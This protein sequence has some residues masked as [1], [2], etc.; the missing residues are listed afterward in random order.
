MQVLS[1]QKRPFLEKWLERTLATYPSQTHRFLHDEKDRFRNPVGHTLRE[2]LATIL[3]ELTGEMDP[4]RIG[5]ALESIVRLRAVQDFTPSQAVGFVY[6]LRE[7]LD[8]ELGGE[9][10]GGFTPP[11]R[12]EPAITPGSSLAVQKRIDDLALRAFDLFMKCREEI[13]EIK[14]REAQRKVY[15]LERLSQREGS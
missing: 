2:G 13:Y 4:A 15:V 10:S 5:P 7:V 14:A 12:G 3:D 9:R 1:E 11:W 6:L 8:E